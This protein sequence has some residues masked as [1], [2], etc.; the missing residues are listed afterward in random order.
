MSLDEQTSKECEIKPLQDSTTENVRRVAI[1]GS[2]IA[3]LCAALSLGE[4]GVPSIIIEKEHELGGLCAQLSCKGVE[5]CVRCD[6]C[7][8]RDKI[9]LV[10]DSPGVEIIKD[11]EVM[12]L[13]GRPGDFILR[14]TKSS[15]LLEL[16]VG[17]VICSVGAIPFHPQSD[18][19]LGYGE[20][21]DVI[22]SLEM[23]K[24]LASSGRILVP[25]TAKEPSSLAFVQCVGSRD[26]RLRA[27]YCS[28]YCCKSSFKLAQAV[29]TRV[30]ACSVTFFYMD[31]RLQ[32][33]RENI[34]LWASLQ[35]NVELIR[36]RPSEILRGEDGRPLVRFVREDESIVEE[37]SFDLVVLATGLRPVTNARK[38]SAAL[39]IELDA[40]G[41]ISTST[42]DRWCSSRAGVFVAGS[43]AGPKD[44]VASAEDG[45]AAASRAIALLEGRS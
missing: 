43:C 9:K 17:A 45:A 13:E 29:K 5:R 11:A 7:L 33:P 30:P 37:R 24:G 40:F 4:R 14:L 22:T 18:R 34:R 35:E 38:L 3:G 31:L 44:I 8:A 36:S 20:V 27:S 26:D 6:V 19:R 2:G 32:D 23:E 41:F 28:S 42:Y 16:K 21:A 12:A 10:R 1:I 25:S 39:G 15:Q